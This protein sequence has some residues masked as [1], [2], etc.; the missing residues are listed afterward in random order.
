MADQ[1]PHQ[2]GD[3]VV[4]T[5]INLPRNQWPLGRVTE[6]M[7]SEDGRVRRAK[8]RISGLMGSNSGVSAGCRWSQQTGS[9]RGRRGCDES[10]LDHP[11]DLADFERA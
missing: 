11:I 4:V 7:K 5:D 1:R 3:M 2:P 8:I 9:V 10:Y 6:A